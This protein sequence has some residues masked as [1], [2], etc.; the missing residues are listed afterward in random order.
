MAERVVFP[1]GEGFLDVPIAALDRLLDVALLGPVKRSG[2]LV[3]TAEEALPA[4]G[5]EVFLMGYPLEVA[6]SPQPTI[7]R[8]ILSRVRDSVLGD[9]SYL[10]TDATIAGGLSGGFLVSASGVFLGMSGFVWEGF[11]M[12]L[13]ADDLR[14]QIDTMLGPNKERY[15]PAPY[16]AASLEFDMAL[17]WLWDQKGFT[18]YVPDG[19]TTFRA[20]VSGQADLRLTLAAGTDVFESVD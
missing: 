11:G 10:Q 4:I 13:A 3:V 12:A 15:R 6:T 5:A 9:V 18:V 2:G 14:L 20:S 8:G 17:D 7:T 19:W 16:F 1:D